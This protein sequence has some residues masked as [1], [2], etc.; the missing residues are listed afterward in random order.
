MVVVDKSWW[1]RTGS[2][3]AEDRFKRKRDKSEWPSTGS[4]RRRCRVGGRCQ[5]VIGECSWW[6]RSR[7]V[8]KG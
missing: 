7:V 6:L 5:L 8:G 3:E 4:S 1:R 2:Y